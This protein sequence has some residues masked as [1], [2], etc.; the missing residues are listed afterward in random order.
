MK[1][2]FDKDVLNNKWGSYLMKSLQGNTTS[3]NVPCIFI[4]LYEYYSGRNNFS[5]FIVDKGEF[6]GLHEVSFDLDDIEIDW[7]CIPEDYSNLYDIS[8]IDAQFAGGFIEEKVLN[9]SYLMG[10]SGI[11]FEGNENHEN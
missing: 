6:H 5:R 8:Y 9:T 2:I 7:K 3:D 4:A 10:K 11:K 1:I